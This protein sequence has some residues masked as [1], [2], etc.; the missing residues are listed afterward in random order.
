MYNW[1][2][3]IFNLNLLYS[4]TVILLYYDTCDELLSLD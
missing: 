2:I 1:L 4:L 3:I